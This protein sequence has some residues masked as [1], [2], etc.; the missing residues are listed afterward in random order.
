MKKTYVSIS[1]AALL[2]VSCNANKSSYD[3]EGYF[4]STEVTVSSEANG[5]ILSFDI[6]EGMQVEA[7]AE[8]GCID[9]VQLYLS[10]MQLRKNAES[11]LENRP[12]IERQ[13]SA[14]KEQLKSVRKEKARV[15]SLLAD[16]AAT[17]KQLDDI[18][19]QEAVLENQIEAQVTAL[20]NS[21]SSLDA[22]SSGIGMQ[23]ARIEDQLR[24]CR[25]K[26][27]VAGTVLTKYSEAGEFASVGR[28]LFKVADL[29]KVYL[30]VY[31]TSAQLSG[32]SLGQQVKVYSDYGKGYSKEYPGT[33]TWISDS[34]EFTP[35]NI[36]TDDERKNLVYAVKVSVENDGLI[37]LGMYGGVVF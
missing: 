10:M 14:L 28:P 16:G 15:E 29:K 3:A 32:I 31:V 11:V 24:K 27:P 37:K 30:R 33:V 22:Q 36:Q 4:E 18:A 26:S 2:V 1:L 8:L 34:S 12:D 13:T 7:G 17:Q 20:G 35:K 25:I 9:T 19:A 23:I 6:E 5:R 21:V